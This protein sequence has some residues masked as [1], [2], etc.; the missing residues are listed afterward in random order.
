MG[1]TVW[2]P[3]PGQL[4]EELVGAVGPVGLPVAEHFLVKAEGREQQI[5]HVPGI[6]QRKP[7]PS[8]IK[9]EPPQA[10][11]HGAA[12]NQDSASVNR[13]AGARAAPCNQ[14]RTNS[15]FRQGQAP[16][17]LRPATSMRWM[18]MIRSV[19]KRRG[20]DRG[21][22]RKARLQAETL[23][24]R[25]APVRENSKIARSFFFGVTSSTRS[26]ASGWGRTPPTGSSRARCSGSRLEHRRGLCE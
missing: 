1:R 3:R 13:G 17:P 16:W 10:P 11:R 5:Q 23:S 19:A 18:N 2:R 6:R 9:V 7:E 20:P 4:D 21:S 15:G 14:E 25:G 26:G 24:R 8:R 22:H 12:L